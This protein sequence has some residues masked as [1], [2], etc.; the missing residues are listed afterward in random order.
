MDIPEKNFEQVFD[1]LLSFL[2]EKLGDTKIDFASPPSK[3]EG[4]NE[5]SIFHFKLR[6]VQP[7]RS[8]PLVLRQ[9]RKEHRPNHA[10]MEKIVHN[11]LVDQGFPVPYVHYSCTNNRYLGSQFLIMDFLPG[12]KL[13]LVLGP[14]TDIVLGKTHAAPHNANAKRLMKDMIAEGFGWRQYIIED[15]LNLLGKA[16]ESLPWLEEIVRWLIENRPSE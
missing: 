15:K 3:L 12:E 4:G 2:K 14:D 10:I 16:S 6:A 8:K 11:S 9:F 7:S 13:P 5:T 1:N